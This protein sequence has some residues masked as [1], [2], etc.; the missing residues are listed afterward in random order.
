MNL[1]LLVIG[2]IMIYGT[3]C[4][5]NIF[6]INYSTNTNAQTGYSNVVVNI[7]LKNNAR[8]QG[9]YYG[10]ITIN[11]EK[12]Q[13]NGNLPNMNGDTTLFN[14]NFDVKHF[15]DGCAVF[16]IQCEITFPQIVYFSINNFINIPCIDQSA[17]QI[18]LVVSNI[19]PTSF[20]IEG[21]S[22]ANCVD[23]KY[24][25]DGGNQWQQFSDASGLSAAKEI[26][27]LTENTEYIVSIQA[28]KD[29]FIP[30]IIGTS[31]SETITTRKEQTPPLISLNVT[32]IQPY[33]LTI[34]ATSNVECDQW[35]YKINTEEWILFDGSSSTTR[36]TIVTDLSDKTE[37]NV[38]VK[39]RKIYNNVEGFSEKTVKTP[40]ENSPPKI[41]FNISNIQQAA[42]EIQAEANLPCEMWK[43][44]LNDGEYIDF[45]TSGKTTN[46]IINDLKP[47]TQY[48]I[49][50]QATKSYNKIIGYALA[51]TITT[52]PQIKTL[53]SLCK[54]PLVIHPFMIL[55]GCSKNN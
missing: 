32:N 51:Q 12:S 23:W 14:K 6:C 44:S 45:G 8:T 9:D 50:I 4:D 33:N 39:A 24:S 17:P 38:R 36:S 21:K 28:R 11:N 54:K 20:I 48:K 10:S 29:I 19:Q 30:D 37:Y 22:D 42:I 5:R 55:L 46:V 7:F 49:N 16:K 43:Y 53:A 1:F 2:I 25:L 41:I 35:K 34:E 3:Q 31:Q 47:N 18:Q 40:I 13:F 26:T 52:L 15:D 27:G